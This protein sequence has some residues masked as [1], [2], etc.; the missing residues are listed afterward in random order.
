VA[1]YVAYPLVMLAATPLFVAWLGT[2]GY[3]VWMIILAV[4]GLGSV[5]NLGM[6]TATMRFVSARRGAGDLA[7]AAAVVRQTFTVAALGGA[8]V[9][10]A[11]ALAAPWVN[12]WGEASGAGDLRAAVRLGAALVF[13]QQLELVFAAALKG[14]ERFDVAAPI[15]IAMRLASVAAG[16]AAAYATRDLVMVLAA[17]VAVSAVSVALRAGAASR[18][19]GAPVYLP[20]RLGSIPGEVLRY[21]AW[22]CGQG[23]AG[24]LLG[25]LDRLVIGWFLGATAVTYYSVC[26]QL[27]QQA[28]ALP[29]AALAFVLPLMS[30]RAASDPD[31]GAGRVQRRALA[32]GAGLTLLLAA[33]LLVLGVPFMNLWM[34]EAFTA[35]AG[36]L[37]P[38]LVAA[39]AL[40]GLN[41]AP[42]YLLLGTGAARFV[43]L[44][45]VAGGLASS[46]G[47]VLLVPA[48]GLVGGAVARG[49]YG[50]VL[51]ASYARLWGARNA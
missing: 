38:W 43:S 14:Y 33:A 51:L 35:Q 21:G 32:A 22:T 17:G 47:A 10:A 49:L 39:Y 11:V 6:G 19:A 1:E 31:A 13:L 44:S 45:N 36:P 15:E 37:L 28:H 25:H 2:E 34:G 9:A 41:V 48:L 40:L 50:P 4:V 16:L 27:A 42:H 24:A 3:G 12:G 8:V 29:A 46:I 30:R 26:T 23:I 20:V 18:I 7:A 5:A